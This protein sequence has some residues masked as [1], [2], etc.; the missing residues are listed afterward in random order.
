MT[1]DAIAPDN[2]RYGKLPFPL[3]DN[4]SVSQVVRRHWWFLWPKSIVMVLAAIIP[5]SII[6]WIMAATDTYEGIAATIFWIVAAVWLLYWAVRI[7]FNWYQYHNDIWVITNQRIID[8]IKRHPFSHR[9]ATTDLV[10]VQDITVE[11][12]GVLPSVLNF[13]DIVVQTAAD[14]ADLVLAGIPRPAEI[15]LFVDKERDRERMRSRG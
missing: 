10:N 14:Q 5:V 4:E 8:S 13:G 6:A 9:L 7:L 2:T 15:Q 11:K 12:H 3:Q 1:T